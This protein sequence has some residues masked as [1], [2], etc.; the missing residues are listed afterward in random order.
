VPVIAVILM[1]FSDRARD[2]SLAFLTGWTLAVA[3]GCAA[4]VAIAGTQDL[5]SGDEPSTLSSWIKLVLGVLLVLV[6]AKQWVSRPAPGDDPPMP[7]WM[8]RIDGLE[9]GAA[10][11]LSI[12][13]AVVNPKNLL[14]IIGAGVA[15]AQ[16]ELSDGENIVA[17][18]VFTAIA[19]CSVAIPTFAYLVLGIRAKPALDRMRA[20]LSANNTAV[21]AV[22]LLVLGV[23]LFGKGLGG[24]T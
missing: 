14:L 5:T 7:G 13:L 20:W 22:L 17:A 2:N 9:P 8:E 12:L 23:S 1:L 11:G 6:A 24:L 16:A 18:L 10:L 3:A 4:V 21:M 19:A 15:I